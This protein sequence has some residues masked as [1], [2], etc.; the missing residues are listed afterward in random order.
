VTDP[1]NSEPRKVLMHEGLFQQLGA[2]RV[3]WG[4]PDA[5]GFYTPTVY[6]PS[7]LDLRERLAALEHEQWIKWSQTVAEQGL[8]A[9]RIERW[10]R[11]WVPYADLD[12][13]TKDFDREWADKV[14]A[15]LLAEQQSDDGME[16]A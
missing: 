10:R 16:G 14:L 7:Y 3:E 8:T 6:T 4:E 5:D 1:V 11:F 13:G 9:E 15:L 12:E 2:G